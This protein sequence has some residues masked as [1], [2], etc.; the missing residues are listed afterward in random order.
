M[1]PNKARYGINLKTR[2]SIEDNPIKGEILIAKEQAEE[3]VKKCQELE[4]SWHKTKEIQA[5]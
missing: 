3:V 4:N 5:K 1:T 2:Q